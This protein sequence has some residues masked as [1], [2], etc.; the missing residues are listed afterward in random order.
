MG[1]ITPI[2]IAFAIQKA[3]EEKE[4]EEEGKGRA[5]I[6][7]ILFGRENSGFGSRTF[8][9]QKVGDLVDAEVVLSQAGVVSRVLKT[10]KRNVSTLSTGKEDR[11]HYIH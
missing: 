4:E 5:E 11:G 3:E 6:P 2:A 1:L 8:N 7:K 9:G 10:K